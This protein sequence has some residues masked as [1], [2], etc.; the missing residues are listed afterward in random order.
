MIDHIHVLPGHA[1]QESTSKW[2]L[3]VPLAFSPD[4]SLVAAISDKQ[5][6]NVWKVQAAHSPQSLGD[7]DGKIQ[8]VSFSADSGLLASANS[9]GRIYVWDIS[10]SSLR[11][12]FV[13]DS[14]ERN[15]YSE[16]I[17][18]AFS[19]KPG[20]RLLAWAEGGTINISDVDTATTVWSMYANTSGIVALSFLPDGQRL[21]SGGSSTIRVWD[22]SITPSTSADLRLDSDLEHPVPAPDGGQAVCHYEARRTIGIWNIDTGWQRLL[23]GV[24]EAQY[25]T[26]AFSKDGERLARATLGHLEIY[27]AKTGNIL[28]TIPNSTEEPFHG[29]AFRHNHEI[30]TVSL[31]G[32]RLW[33]ISTADCICALDTS[34]NDGHI[35]CLTISPDGNWLTYARAKPG[36]LDEAVIPIWDVRAAVI[37]LSLHVRH[38]YPDQIAL[39]SDNLLLA[40]GS[41][42]EIEVWDTRSGTNLL[43]VQD[44]TMCGGISFDTHIGTRL[45]TE[46]GFVDFNA[47]SLG[48]P[49]RKELSRKAPFSGYGTCPR[50]QNSL[51][52]EENWLMRNGKKVLWIPFDYQFR[53]LEDKEPQ[54]TSFINGKILIWVSYQRNELMRIELADP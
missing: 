9:K 10:T 30:A 20:N 41:R 43:S 52:S 2:S 22:I 7:T 16:I 29:F 4:N 45:H 27:N 50:Q 6:I 13:F 5:T 1:E 44:R 24:K 21:A 11:K 18:L 23:I 54:L 39:S 40:L 19:P 35:S 14:S 3:S 37:A 42:G 36:V 34:K 17:R 46:H 28:Q 48:A 26:L 38:A 53:A 33:D 47:E 49:D 25:S 31:D 8:A 51:N 12:K 15:N 32:V